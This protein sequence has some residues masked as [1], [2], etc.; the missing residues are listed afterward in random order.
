MDHW[1]SDFLG[2]CSDWFV[3]FNQ[4]DCLTE[5]ESTVI[6]LNKSVY[7]VAA[8]FSNSPFRFH[9]NVDMSGLPV[10][11]NCIKVGDFSKTR[12]QFI[13]VLGILFVNTSVTNR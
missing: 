4:M 11:M 2:C 13:N 9:G 1:I 3:Y 10:N 5:V 12:G 8:T 6:I 7:Y